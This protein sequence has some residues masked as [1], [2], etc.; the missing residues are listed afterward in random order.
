M[1]APP[2]ISINKLLLSLN[3]K[4]YTMDLSMTEH[5]DNRHPTYHHTIN[6]KNN[7]V[8]WLPYTDPSKIC[9]T[10]YWDEKQ[11]D[12]KPQILKTFAGEKLSIKVFDKTGKVKLF[13]KKCEVKVSFT[14]TGVKNGQCWISME[15]GTYESGGA[16]DGVC[17]GI[18]S[19]VYKDYR[20]V[21]LEAQLQMQ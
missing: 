21:P 10:Y 2:K 19:L 17:F 13:D 15:P 12:N 20:L 14:D 8:W 9:S 16:S 6:H 1:S 7:G 5:H 11:P 4:D 18:T 3:D